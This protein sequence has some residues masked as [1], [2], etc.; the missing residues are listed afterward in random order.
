MKRRT[1]TKVIGKVITLDR[2]FALFHYHS[3]DYGLR[4]YCMIPY[5]KLDKNGCVNENIN[6]LEMRTGQTIH[7]ALKYNGLEDRRT[8]KIIF[9]DQ[10]PPERD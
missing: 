10:I 1:I 5:E 7:E 9:F 8:R 2:E 6:I 4:G 3:L